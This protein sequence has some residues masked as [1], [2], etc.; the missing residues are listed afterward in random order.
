M[1]ISEEHKKELSRE[2]FER[3]GTNSKTE[4]EKMVDGIISSN[5]GDIPDRDEYYSVATEAF[6]QAVERYDGKQ[7]FRGFLYVVVKNK[8]MSRLT[9]NNGATRSVGEIREKVNKDGKIVKQR[10]AVPNLSLDAKIGDN[11]T[12][13]ADMVASNSEIDDEFLGEGYQ[14]YLDS[15][16]DTQRELI[17]MLAD[18]YTAA[19]IQQR[20]RL[21]PKIY[22]SELAAARSYHHTKWIIKENS[23]SHKKKGGS[24]SETAQTSK[25]VVMTVTSYVDSVHNGD[26]CLEFSGQRLSGQ[27]SNPQKGTLIETMLQGYQIPA[28]VVCEQKMKD[29]F[30]VNWIIDGMQRTS[31]LDEFLADGFAVARNIERPIISY[32]IRK[33]DEKGRVLLENGIP[34]FETAE[35]DIRN[36]KFSAFPEELQKKIKDYPL[37]F[38][39]YLGCTAEDV[40][41]HIRRYNGGKPMNQ[42]QKGQTHL[43]QE[44][45]FLVNEVLKR[46]F[47]KNGYD[48]MITDQPERQICAELVREKL[49]KCLDK[50]IPHGTAVEI[51]RF[52]EREDGVVEKEIGELADRMD[53]VLSDAT[54][55]EV[56]R[57]TDSFIFFAA[58]KRFTEFGLPDSR[59][60][61]FMSAFVNGLKEKPVN[62]ESYFVRDS[63]KN[64]A[65]R[66]K[67]IVL[68]KIR[69][70]FSL[71]NEFFGREDEVPAGV[72]NG[73]E[74]E[75]EDRPVSREVD[76][77]LD[78]YVTSFEALKVLPEGTSR[79]KAERSAIQVALAVAG[80]E[81]PSDDSLAGE[82][83]VV[84]YENAL[85][86]TEL[87]RDEWLAG[88]PVSPS[89][90][91]AMVAAYRAVVDN[92]KDPKEQKE[93]VE[94][95]DL[96]GDYWTDY[97]AL[98]SEGK[99][100]A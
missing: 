7:P 78:S 89:S 59:F 3:K 35:F 22:A 48:D 94:K 86:Y 9:S 1:I 5:F 64:R 6:L 96:T 11:D 29:G 61:D 65:T 15:L 43:G 20:L 31:V 81:E 74:L 27:W 39:M 46:P 40:E 17:L 52:S 4:L 13:I 95:T 98:T 47:F 90:L 67:R 49:L 69:Q 85:L 23:I 16:P 44:F 45:A 60:E 18:G 8:V 57:Q 99:R 63:A 30:A 100:T 12:T 38:E 58:F 66:N 28:L 77:E 51:T 62:G 88:N 53:A 24:M 72:E 26:W 91:P 82:L 2:Y 14:K 33:K 56:T 68:G 76:P 84:D 80:S 55:E 87:C 19:E 75:E 83:T 32:Q 42:N 93:A 97:E 21:S 41:Y 54:R 70:I 71:M 92:G 79:S 34:V 50:E 10:V 36:K 25:Q 73:Q 37:T